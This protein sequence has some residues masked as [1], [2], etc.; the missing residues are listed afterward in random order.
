MKPISVIIFIFIFFN[1]NA[2]DDFWALDFTPHWRPKITIEPTKMIDLKGSRI[3]PK[4]NFGFH[5]GLQR[6]KPLKENWGWNYGFSVGTFQ[7]KMTHLSTRAFLDMG[8]ENSFES[9]SSIF[10]QGYVSALSGINYSFKLQENSSLNISLA[11]RVSYSIRSY[12]DLYSASI[13]ETGETIV[14]LY[15][16]MVVNDNNAIFFSADC[17]AFYLYQ[18][19]KIPFGI[20]TGW[21]ISYSPAKP[22]RGNLY[23]FGDE[24]TYEAEINNNFSFLGASLGIVYFPK[25]TRRK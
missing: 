10:D 4:Y 18:F 13:L 2:Q 15:A 14:K 24:G 17:D 23:F 1:I 3:T 19:K 25:G 7:L 16:E 21:T 8:W 22:M 11:G 6:Y 20:K 12:L 5:A 9:I